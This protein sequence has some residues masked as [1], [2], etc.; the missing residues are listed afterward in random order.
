VVQESFL[1]RRILHFTGREV[2]WECDEKVASETFPERFP[3][4]QAEVFA[5]L[6]KLQ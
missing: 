5:R 3:Q 1:S 2:F 6:V 4:L